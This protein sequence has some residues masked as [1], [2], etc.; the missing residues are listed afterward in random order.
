[1]DF[2]V[3]I[4]QILDAVEEYHHTVGVFAEYDPLQLLEAYRYNFKG[5]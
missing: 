1:M 3:A 5:D 2:S 4:F